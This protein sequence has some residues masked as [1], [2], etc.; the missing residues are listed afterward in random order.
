[1]DV[2]H[3]MLGVRNG[4]KGWVQILAPTNPGLYPSIVN[5]DVKICKRQVA[6]HKAE[7][8]KFETSVWQS[9]KQLDKS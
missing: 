2:C 7:L 8:V 1:M 9:R 5:G 6:E 3:L 4:Y